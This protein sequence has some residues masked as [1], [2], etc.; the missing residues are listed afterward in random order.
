ML[1]RSSA[2]PAGNFITI[3][4]TTE[5]A[6]GIYAIALVSDIPGTRELRELSL[7]IR[8]PHGL[9]LIVGCSHPGIERIV[10]A[11]AALDAQLHVIFGGFHMPA[12]PDAE[13]ARVATA[14]HEQWKV[15]ELAPGHCTGEPAFAHFKRVWGLRYRHAGVGTVLELP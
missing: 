5:I 2:W 6:P 11:A 8:T 1:F 3:E 15:K 7:A 10:Q 12:A 9:I 4:Q 13:V 14:L